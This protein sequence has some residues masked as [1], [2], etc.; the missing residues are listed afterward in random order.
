MQLVYY[1]EDAAVM[2]GNKMAVLDLGWPCPAED[3]AFHGA[4]L[5]F[6]EIHCASGGG[7]RH[8]GLRRRGWTRPADKQTKREI[9]NSDGIFHTRIGSS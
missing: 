4:E 1:L 3:A 6:D 9:G 5:L 8:V 7:G 2:G